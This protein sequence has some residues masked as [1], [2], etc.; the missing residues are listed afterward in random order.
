MKLD[1][2]SRTTISG[3]VYGPRA[4]F[5]LSY[6]QARKLIRRNCHMSYLRYLIVVC[7]GDGVPNPNCHVWYMTLVVV[8]IV[9]IPNR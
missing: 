6:H 5:S 1:T 8:V 3:L 4:S 7:W 9:V 2:R